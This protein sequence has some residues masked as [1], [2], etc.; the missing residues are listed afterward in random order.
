[1]LY[2]CAKTKER[3][4]PKP[5]EYP[6]PERGCI[7]A[8]DFGDLIPNPKCYDPLPEGQTFRLQLSSPLSPTL[9]PLLASWKD[10]Y[11]WYALDDLLDVFRTQPTEQQRMLGLLAGPVIRLQ[12]RDSIDFFKIW[13]QQVW[14]EETP[15]SPNRFLAADRRPSD[16]TTLITLELCYQESRITPKPTPLW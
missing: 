7:G 6:R 8:D 15:V 10:K 14:M 1:M 4:E 5:L 11:L 9:K 3:R 13:I 12:N 16:S 2:P